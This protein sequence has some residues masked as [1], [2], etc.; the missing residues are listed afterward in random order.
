MHPVIRIVVLAIAAALLVTPAAA[1]PAAEQPIVTV[2]R[3]GGFC[4][5]RTACTKVLRITDT[6][7]SGEGYV[8]RRL[9][10]A[11]RAA[12]LRA[13]AALDVKSLR[14]FRG[15]CPTS[16]DV[17]ESVYRFRGIARTLPECKYDLERVKAVHLT[18]RLLATLKPRPRS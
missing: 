8:P 5:A 3:R 11:D 14:P 7:V 18:D 2:T 10:K 17:P 1:A 6:T 4:L 9:A 15:T 16:H 12:L 13:I